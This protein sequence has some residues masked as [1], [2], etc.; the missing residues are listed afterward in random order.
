MP[1][2]RLRLSSVGLSTIG[3]AMVLTATLTSSASGLSQIIIALGA[4]A[5][6]LSPVIEWRAHS[7]G[8]P[9]RIGGHPESGGDSRAEFD[10]W[11]EQVCAS[12]EE[13]SRQLDH[14]RQKL[15]DQLLRYHEFL[16]YP[17]IDSAENSSDSPPSNLSERDREV[18]RIL[19]SEAAR[20][21]EKIR[22]D[23]YRV[24][25]YLDSATIRLEVLDVIQRVA[26]VYSP[27]SANPI[28]ETSFDQL[29]RAASRVCLQ[30]LVLV[31]QLPLDVQHYTV[32]ELYNY[33]RGAVRAWGAW[34]TV[35][36]WITR[37]SRGMYAGRIAAGSSPVTFGAWW[38][39]TEL[40]RRGSKKLVENYV[41]Q[42]A[43]AFFNDAVRLVGN[44][45][46]CVYGPGIRQRDAAWAYGA[47][48]TELHH[49]FPPSRESLQAS[50]REVTG[51]PL[52]SEY[53]RIYLYR[54][55]AEHKAS[56]LRVTDP[57][58]LTRDEREN[59]AARLEQFFRKYIHGAT[60]ADVRRWHTSV[61]DHLDRC[62]R[63]IRS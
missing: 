9:R 29:A 11:R 23:G 62:V 28:M 49:R 54:C 18:N 8:A 32:A 40:G 24:D 25:G 10:T 5:L 33:V 48:L 38:V 42:R 1:V 53:D 20:V 12:L 55:L 52:R 13:Q 37:L 35:S 41:D 60:D 36:P 30:A 16:E 58:V 34:Q 43:V 46:A 59:I 4:L 3:C 21:Y 7:R 19:E 44:E 56:G 39:A 61:E 27:D 47:E 50:L 26:R 15:N 63:F 57:M 2:T 22:S 17:A 31:E 14:R 51:L 45:V 6:V